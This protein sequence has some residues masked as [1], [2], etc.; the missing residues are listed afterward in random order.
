MTKK[1]NTKKLISNEEEEREKLLLLAKADDVKGKQLVVTETGTLE[2]ED[3]LKKFLATSIDDPQKKYELY[4]K[5]IM[6]LLKQHLPKGNSNKRARNYIYEEKNTYLTR[7]KRI[8]L[9]G[10]RGADSRMTYIDDAEEMLDII[11]KWVFAK[12]T[13]VELFTQ[14]R[15]LNIKKGYGTRKF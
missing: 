8:N 9:Q 6:R 1:T 7:G 11:A 2:T 4:Y 10:Y 5:G 13:M 15:D 3:E 14:L 12:G